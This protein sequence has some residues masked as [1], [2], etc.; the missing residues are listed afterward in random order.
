MIGPQG[1]A[2]PGRLVLITL[3]GIAAAYQVPSTMT[4][5]AAELL[6][7]VTYRGFADAESGFRWSG[8]RS[9]VVFP[10]PGPRWPVRVEVVLSA[11]R[12]RG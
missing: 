11:W 3:L 4:L 6:S 5:R 10:D 1:S 8:A 2:A 9:E 7:A 12:P